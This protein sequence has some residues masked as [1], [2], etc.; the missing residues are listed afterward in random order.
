M[1]LERQTSFKTEKTAPPLSLLVF[2]DVDLSGIPGMEL[3][4]QLY[5]GTM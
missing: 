2:L 1:I 5:T 3:K 4:V